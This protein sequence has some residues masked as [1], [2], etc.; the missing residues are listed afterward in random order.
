MTRINSF[1]RIAAVVALTAAIAVPSFAARGSANFTTFVAVGDSYGAGYESSSLNERHQIFGWP[2]IVAR[3][4][5][6]PICQPNP[7]A[8]D[9]CFALPLISYP[10]LP[11]GELVLN[12][13]GTGITQ[14]PGSGGPAMF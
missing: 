9:A 6:L 3:Q 2:A 11:A 4:V 1:A 7:S 13:T 14:I 12:A 8:T 5:G 10:G